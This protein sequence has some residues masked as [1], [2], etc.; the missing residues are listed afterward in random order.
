MREIRPRPELRP[1]FEE[2]ML[3]F[4]E[5]FFGHHQINRERFETCWELVPQFRIQLAR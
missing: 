4:E 3:A 2:T 1:A 5:V